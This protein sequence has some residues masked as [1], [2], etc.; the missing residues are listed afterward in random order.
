MSQKMLQDELNPQAHSPYRVFWGDPLHAV[1]M[2]PQEALY[3]WVLDARLEERM[4]PG[5]K[6]GPLAVA[7]SRC[8]YD[9]KHQL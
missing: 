8:H 4:P 7:A 2:A 6:P 1:A 3:L 9:T 5:L